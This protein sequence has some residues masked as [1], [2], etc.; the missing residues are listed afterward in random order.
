[1]KKALLVM[2]IAMA[3]IFAR[4]QLLTPWKAPVECDIPT[5]TKLYGTQMSAKAVAS[6]ASQRSIKAI[7]P[8]ASQTWW[9]Y[10]S[11][12]NASSLDFSGNLAMVLPLP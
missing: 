9:G 10:F 3:A 7:T 11:E 8:T 6:T 4:A 1:M 5:V 12:S 2:A